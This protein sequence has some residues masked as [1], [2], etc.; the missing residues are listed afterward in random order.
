MA[1]P[2]NYNENT[3]DQVY[4]TADSM[5]ADL[6]LFDVPKVM[7]DQDYRLIWT[8]LES[9]Y[10]DTPLSSNYNETRWKMKLQ[11]IMWEYGPEWKKKLDIQ[12]KL[13]TLSDEEILSGSKAIYN[14]AYNPGGSPDTQSLEEIQYINDQ[15]TTNYKKSKMDAYTILWGYLNSD[16]TAKFMDKFKPLFSKFALTDIPLYLYS[17]DPTEG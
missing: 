5:I 1:N 7:T 3:F 15:N 2:I 11:I 16:M 9:K 12:Q 14:H 17:D 10:G 6:T 4:P 8:L 13:R